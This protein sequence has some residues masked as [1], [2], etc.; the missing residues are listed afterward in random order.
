MVLL[1]ARCVDVFSGI[2]LRKGLNK[3][4]SPCGGM[5]IALNLYEKHDVICWLRLNFDA[6]HLNLSFIRIN[7][8]LMEGS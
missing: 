5:L 6:Q 7:L 3:M 4:Q 2:G 8:F 1:I